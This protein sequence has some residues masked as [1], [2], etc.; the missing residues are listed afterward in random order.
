MKIGALK[1]S[2]TILVF[3]ILI[4]VMLY[5]GSSLLIPLTFAIFLSTL[6]LPITNLLETKLG[7]GRLTS[8][9]VS[10]LIVF[11]GLGAILFLM[12][13]QVNIF[14]RELIATQG[15]IVD[16]VKGLQDDIAATTG[17]TLTQQ[18]QLLK[19]SLTDIIDL[20]QRHLTGFLTNIFELIFQFLLILIYIFLLLLNRDK[21]VEFL[22]MYKKDEKKQETLDVIS[23][24]S[25]IAHNYLWGRVKV[26]ALLAIMYFIVFTA[27]DLKYSGLLILFGALITIIP[28]L[29]PF[30]S[31]L[32][33]IIVMLVFGDSTLE[34]VSFISIVI[35]VQLIESYVLEPA[36]IG[37]EVE[38]SPLFVIIAVF[39]GGML[40]GP[41]G[42]ILFVPIFAIL[43][44]IFDNTR[45]LRPVGY[46]MGYERK[47]SKENMFE[48]L[49]KKVKF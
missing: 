30:L 11:I 9:F 43:K 7:F 36:I 32:F 13:H 26:M 33:P 48:K 19:E 5:F 49:I 24:T 22:M 3:A 45:E 41:A 31:G 21:F 38:Q 16:F 39:M 10:T 44:I 29:G 23:K 42:L 34:I 35:V 15:V 37:A 40:W 28:Y 14:L 25:K 12:L 47:G 27:Y 18:E 46:L 6:I 1:R 8:S 4:M 2:N 20:T 17:F